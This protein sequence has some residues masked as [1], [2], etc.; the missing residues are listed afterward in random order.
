MH[1]KV[2]PDPSRGVGRGQLVAC[3]IRHFKVDHEVA[4]FA[5]DCHNLELGAGRLQVFPGCG[6]STLKIT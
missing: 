3:Q 6:G 4:L 5:V 1:R 2:Y